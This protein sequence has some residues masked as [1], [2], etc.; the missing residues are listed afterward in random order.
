M[1]IREL[2]ESKDGFPNGPERMILV[3]PPGVGKTYSIMH[4]WLVPAVRS[5][6]SVLA[7]SFTKASAG[8]M[9]DRLATL[10]PGLDDKTLKRTC[11]TLHSEA[12]GM[13]LASGGTVSILKDGK[14]KPVGDGD[15]LALAGWES[16][17]SPAK[18]QRKEAIRIWDLARSVNFPE[19]AG[20]SIASLV[21]SIVPDRMES[22]L[23]HRILVAEIESYCAEKEAAGVMDF[24]DLLVRAVS[25]TPRSRDLLIVDE[26]Q[27]LSPLQLAL[28]E[29]IA[30]ASKRVVFVG[31]PDQA[32]FEFS[33]ADGRYLTEQIRSGVEA[34]RLPKSR[35]VPN[36]AHAL[37]RAL[38]KRN[39]DR[40]DSPYESSGEPGSI[41]THNDHGLACL[42]LVSQIEGGADGAFVL[43]RSRAALGKIAHWLVQEGVPF[44]GERASSPVAV[45]R[46]GNKVN[47]QLVV[48]LDDLRERGMIAISAAVRLADLLPHK[49]GWFAGKKKATVEALTALMESDPDCRVDARTLTKAG[50]MLARITDAPTLEA[51]AEVAGVE[52]SE[53]LMRVVK[54][55]GVEAL[56]WTPPITLTTYHTSKGREAEVVMVDMD[57]PYPCALSIERNDEGESSERRA[58]YVAV[59]RT[60]DSMILLSGTGRNGC[61]G[62]RLGLDF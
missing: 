33:G 13:I 44:I 20:D 32:I 19:R 40:V 17:M 11:K 5:G 59:T 18:D 56:R 30:S 12:L 15:E 3:G 42:D 28:A 36:A 34:R 53:L 27:D 54:R 49:G 60:K 62:R 50:L 21:N 61:L 46:D 57:C 7:T 47:A 8:E 16:M 23:S 4:R 41:S 25:L 31:D 24:T 43:G 26:A 14:H 9:R 39:T 29:R 48:G 52:E 10:V 58:L 35:R 37:A 38:I 22:N 45:G 2:D 55:Y 51:A 6:A 1:I